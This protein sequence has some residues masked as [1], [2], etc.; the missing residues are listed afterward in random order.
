[1]LVF[2][3][4]PFLAILDLWTVFV[5]DQASGG[6]VPAYGLTYIVSTDRLIGWLPLEFAG[7]LE[8]G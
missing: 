5:K 8:V 7:P 6:E 2:M 1:M 3:F 4:C